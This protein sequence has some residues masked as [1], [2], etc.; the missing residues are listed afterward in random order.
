M[1]KNILLYMAGF[2]DGE[3]YVGILKRNR[4]KWNTEY[5][6]QASIGQK[7]GGTMDWIIDNFGGHLHRVKRDNSYCWIVSNKEAYRILKM[8]AP[9]LKYKKPQALLAIEYYENRDLRRPI[10]AKELER[11][12]RIYQELK[13]IKHIFTQSH[14]KKFSNND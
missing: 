9:Y 1:N 3:G 6:I 11:R 2:F 14:N 5:F 12:E 7:D 4:K 8:I 10:P 13:S